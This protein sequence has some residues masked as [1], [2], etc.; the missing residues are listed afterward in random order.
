MDITVYSKPLCVQCDATKRA[1]NK[2]GVAYD[3]VDVTEDAEALAH[4]KS[5]GYV[6]APVVITGEDHWSG[7][8]PDKIKAVVA[9]AGAAAPRRTAAV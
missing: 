5:L 4:I 9:T 3:V 8:R 6:Q 2:A 7:F 1:L